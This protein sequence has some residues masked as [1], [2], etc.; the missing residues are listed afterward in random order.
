MSQIDKLVQA[1]DRFV[2]LPWEGFIAPAQ[3]VWLII[4]QPSDERR[5]RARLVQFESAT[6]SADHGWKLVDVTGAFARWIGSH[7]Y[8]ESYFA[9]PERLS[10]DALKQF[11]SFVVAEVRE[12]LTASDVTEETLVVVLG[13]GALF[14]FTRV[15]TVV[16][17]VESD[18]RGRLAVFFPGERDGS[19]YRLLEARDG[20][21]YLATP[22]TAMEDMP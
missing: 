2:S 9:G 1:F 22:I 6:K 7:P 8:K 15:S 14:P 18:V 12:A 21:N 5:L 4:Y 11:E 16:K 20:W 10:A 3:R 19:N 17:G 13:A